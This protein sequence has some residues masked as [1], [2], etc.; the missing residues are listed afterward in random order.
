[1]S[2][3]VCPVRVDGTYCGAPAAFRVIAM[4]IHEHQLGGPCCATCVHD[5]RRLFLGEQQACL[6]CR[7]G[8]HPHVCPVNV[9]IV[10]LTG[11][12]EQFECSL[13]HGTFTKTR[14]DEEA[15][16]Q[17]ADLWKPIPGDDEEPGI[18]CEGCF[19]EVVAWAEAEVPEAFRRHP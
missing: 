17:M 19:Q 9:E 8:E 18:V 10:S 5:A 7:D 2:T 6:T 3:V 11:I 4:C 16:A 15:Y 14:S 13:C 1:M 12:G